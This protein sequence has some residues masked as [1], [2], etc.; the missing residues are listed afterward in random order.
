MLNIPQKATKKIKI[1]Y[2]CKVAIK[3][4]L[5]FTLL[6]VCPGVLQAQKQGRLKIDSLLK[7]LV[8]SDGDS[9][10]VVL[11]I[12][13][14][15]EYHNI[16]PDTGI[17]YGSSALKL[18]DAL[19]WKFAS[20]RANSALGQNYAAR[21][22]NPTALS[23]YI[24]ALTLFEDVKDSTKIAILNG[25][26]GNVYLSLD[27]YNDALAYAMKALN[28]NKA[29]KDT[30]RLAENMGNLGV[31][32]EQMND[33]ASALAYYNDAVKIDMEL[34]DNAA[35]AKN[36]GNMAGLYCKQK[37]FSSALELANKALKIYEE[38][39]DINS[40]AGN[41]CNIGSIYV[42]MVK[43]DAAAGKM[44][45]ADKQSKVNSAITYLNKGILISKEIGYL[46]GLKDGYD[47]LKDAYT[48]KGDYKT[49]LDYF[50]KYSAIKDS[51]N[52]TENKIKVANV[53]TA[54][55]LDLQKLNLEKLELQAENSK[56]TRI[57]Y[58]AGIVL[59]LIAISVVIK[60]FITEIKSN[61]Q[62]AKERKKHIERIRA[63]KTV[64]KDIAYIQSHEVRGPV[65]TILG[66]TQLFN[67]DDPADPTNAELMEGITTVANRLDKIVTE[68]VNKE[69]KLNS[70][71][72]IESDKEDNI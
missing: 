60:Y 27:K 43:N 65:S 56:K 34:G 51:I 37:N 35:I 49:A 1:Y 58:I 5:I 41:Y 42:A 53:E 57:I 29:H 18:S 44:A 14:S 4:L 50:L 20:G 62:L 12:E 15:K 68:V 45:L 33:Y 8:K 32:Y 21:T 55:Q 31:I 61:R 36:Q 19:Q 10:K 30:V 26:I 54:R 59:L 3:R 9:S 47:G 66:L 69:N 40:A 25:L 7:E 39:G 64:L 2:L 38:I 28:Y 70:A 17:I 63:Q 11:L 23:Y 72:D 22:D 24:K 46:E 48:L 6:L 13:V 16:N 71:A 67:Y 52:S